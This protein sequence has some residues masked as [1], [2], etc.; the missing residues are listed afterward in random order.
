MIF[1]CTNS[2]ATL[3]YFIIPLPSTLIAKSHFYG[4]ISQKHTVL[5]TSNPSPSIL[6][7]P[8]PTGFPPILLTKVSNDLP[9][10]EPQT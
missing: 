7:E 5:I 9:V 8:P 6:S 3:K 1:I 10:P 4:Q 2:T